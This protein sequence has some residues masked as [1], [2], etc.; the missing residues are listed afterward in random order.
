MKISAFLCLPSKTV[1]ENARFIKKLFFT[2]GTYCKEL[3]PP[4]FKD[5]QGSQEHH[6][7]NRLT[8]FS[9]QRHATPAKLQAAPSMI[10]EIKK[11]GRKFVRT[12][13]A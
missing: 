1:F 6:N 8:F 11:P 9:Q 12:G 4:N 3:I 7:P 13:V 2:N 10:S 5:S